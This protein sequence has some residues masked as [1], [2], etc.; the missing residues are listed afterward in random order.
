MDINQYK[1]LNT[2]ESLLVLN[3]RGLLLDEVIY[4]GMLRLRM[5]R[6]ANYYVQAV[7]NKHDDT[8]LEIKPMLSEEDWTPYL[9]TKDLK[10]YF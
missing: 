7:F 2:K 10:N 5:Y 3:R 4:S 8:V 9:E 1:N 6:L